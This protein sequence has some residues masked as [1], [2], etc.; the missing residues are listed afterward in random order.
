M[1]SVTVGVS[2]LDAA[3]R[4][5]A[6]VMQLHIESR[7]RLS[8]ARR[9]AWGIAHAR[10]AECIELSCRGYPIG[11]LRLLELDPPATEHVRLDPT[12][13]GADTPLDIGP[14]TI[15]F[16]VAP[17][18]DKPLGELVATGCVARSAPVRHVIGDT[19]SEEIVLFGPDHVPML[20]RSATATV[21]AAC[22][23]GRRTDRTARCRR[24]RSSRAIRLRIGASTAIA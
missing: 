5:F 15:D 22:A 1:R 9:A 8:P 3:L 19:E 21:R 4:V 24:H 16:Y 11:R 12:V 2:S 6:D 17:P 10:R 14:K 7:T 18:I 20:I 23:R 13:G